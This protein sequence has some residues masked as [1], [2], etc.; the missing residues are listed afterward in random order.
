MTWGIRMHSS[1]VSSVKTKRI[2]SMPRRRAFT[3]IEL[4]VVLAI[5]ATLM[6]LL[7]PA[8]Q[9]VRA[10]AHRITCANN[11]KQIGIAIHH[12]HTNNERFPRYRQ[13]PDWIFNGQ[14]DINC[15]SL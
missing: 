6:A 11:L 5:I 7:L 13:C 1:T 10:T 9:K 8:V 15:T 2:P 3:L 12:Y 14:V 4:L